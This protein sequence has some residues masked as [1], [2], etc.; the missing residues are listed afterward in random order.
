MSLIAPM[1]PAA[2]ILAILAFAH[3]SE[4]WPNLAQLGRIRLPFRLTYHDDRGR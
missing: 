2:G 1:C 3:P 4:L